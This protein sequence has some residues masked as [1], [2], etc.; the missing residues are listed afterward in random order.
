MKKVDKVENIIDG[1]F[2]V[3]DQSS[4]YQYVWN[5]T[6]YAEDMDHFIAATVTDSSGN[7]TNLMPVTVFVDKRSQ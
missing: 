2:S 7:T 6:T 4:P 1:S 3:V 5:T